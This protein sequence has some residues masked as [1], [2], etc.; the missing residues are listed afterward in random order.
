MGKHYVPRQH[1]RRF[2]ID[3]KPEAV[4]MYDKK[5]RRWSDPAVSRIAN[6]PDFY[7]PDVEKGLAQEIEKPGN[8][9]IDKLLRGDDLTNKDRS[10]LSLYMLIMATRGPRH[11]KKVTDVASKALREIAEEVRSEIEAW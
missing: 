4:W 8:I 10:E 2:H 3:G 5:H 1:L 9:V 7:S 6:E 11:R